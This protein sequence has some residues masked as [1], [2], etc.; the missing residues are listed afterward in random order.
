MERA[1]SSRSDSS[2]RAC[3][4]NLV[5]PLPSCVALVR[6][7]ISR[8]LGFPICKWAGHEHLPH[9]AAVR[10]KRVRICKAL[11]VVSALT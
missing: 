10:M 1:G 4:S 3:S 11:R 7:Y 8:R 5:L 2:Q 9:E 6:N